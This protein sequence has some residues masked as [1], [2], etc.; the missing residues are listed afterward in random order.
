MDFQNAPSLL[1]AI[2]KPFPLKMCNIHLRDLIFSRERN[3]KQLKGASMPA[4]PASL[5]GL[6][7]S[8]EMEK[9]LFLNIQAFDENIW[10]QRG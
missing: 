1:P 6:S 8:S 9:R 7:S 5:P 2:Q 3:A 10:P 4:S